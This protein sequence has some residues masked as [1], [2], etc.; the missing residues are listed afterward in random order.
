MT[1]IRTI[2]RASGAAYSGPDAC[3]GPRCWRTPGLQPDRPSA[4]LA[5]RLSNPSI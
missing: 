4:R 5:F 3:V 2:P 1:R